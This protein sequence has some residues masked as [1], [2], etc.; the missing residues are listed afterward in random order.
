[1]A[2]SRNHSRLDVNISDPRAARPR[3]LSFLSEAI[4]QM[5]KEINKKM[6]TQKKE[7]V[8]KFLQYI[9]NSQP[10]LS[11]RCS[12]TP[13]PLHGPCSSAA[14]M[15]CKP[16][17]FCSTLHAPARPQESTLRYLL[18]G[19]KK[20]SGVTSS[21]GHLNW[22]GSFH[23]YTCIILDLLE[24]L[25]SERYQHSKHAQ[26]VY[27]DLE[28]EEIEQ[29]HLHDH[30]RKKSGNAEAAQYLLDFFEGAGQP[31]TVPEPRV[32]RGR[33]MRNLKVEKKAP[34]RAA[35][36]ARPRSESPG[37]RPPPASAA[38]DAKRAEAERKN[39]HGSGSCMTSKNQKRKG[40]L[41]FLSGFFRSRPDPKQLEEKGII[42]AAKVF[43]APLN[44]VCAQYGKNGLP[45]VVV[46]CINKLRKH[47]S[48]EGLFRIPGNN[49]QVI[50]LKQKYD[51]GETVD[52]NDSPPDDV[53]G[54]LKLY[55]RDMPQPLV[56]WASYD[57][58]LHAFREL[59]KDGGASIRRV[60]DSLPD[61][62]QRL[63]RYLFKFF[64]L[65]SLNHA[66]NR[67]K[68]RNIAIC[69]APNILRPKVETLETV[70]QDATAVTG[71]IKFLI[72]D[73]ATER[74]GGGGGG[75]AAGSSTFG[76]GADTSSQRA[77]GGLGALQENDAAPAMMGS[78]GRGA[79][80]LGSVGNPDWAQ[81]KSPQ[82]DPIIGQDEPYILPPEWQEVKRDGKTYY[83][84]QSE[85]RSQWAK[86]PSAPCSRATSRAA[87]AA[88]GSPADMARAQFVGASIAVVGTTAAPSARSAA[89]RRG[90]RHKKVKSTTIPSRAAQTLSGGGGAPKERARSLTTGGEASAGLPTG[91][92]KHVHK[93]SGSVYYYHKERGVSQ[94]TAPT[95]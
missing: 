84:N 62:R 41:Q 47:L 80:A 54:L 39:E 61:Q 52:L 75:A 73:A 4:T 40:F 57:S 93:G 95:D 71:V 24:T 69:L 90:S 85:K 13:P 60:T 63:L 59:K 92:T 48:K 44:R 66:L 35:R 42:K 77:R 5:L 15:P 45:M 12:R 38:A 70:T 36:S 26:R 1:M 50:A 64:H 91:W 83:Y 6:F 67:M 65:L 28:P 79:S 49:T 78:V 56:P 29:L 58:Y 43:G 9:V 87:S 3:P 22:K 14:A 17:P 74:K 82:G 33:S 46:S 11:V 27:L 55:L 19:D 68:S 20:L 25:I 88:I 94:W 76:S 89:T 72:D 31:V 21:V 34:S 81:S 30:V 53:A 7:A 16:D 8:N 2:S 23:R 32:R 18:V 51:Y 10:K 86:P 37:I